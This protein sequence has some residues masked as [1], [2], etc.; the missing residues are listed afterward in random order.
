ML[1]EVAELGPTFLAVSCQ[2][3][4]LR[5]GGLLLLLL[6]PRLF[7]LAAGEGEPGKAKGML[8]RTMTEYSQP[9]GF[10]RIRLHV[11]MRNKR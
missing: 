10:E 7:L 6:R 1:L 3:R 5:C 11:F 2:P 9:E 8:Y 4:G